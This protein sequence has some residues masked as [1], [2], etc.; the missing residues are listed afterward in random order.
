MIGDESLQGALRILTCI[1]LYKNAKHY[2]YHPRLAEAW[3]EPDH[4]DFE[5]VKSMFSVTLSDETIVSTYNR[6]EDNREESIK[7]EAK[8]MLETGEDASFVCMCA[9]ASVIGA[10]IYSHYPSCGARGVKK[11]MKCIVMPREEVTESTVVHILWSRDSDFDNRPKVKYH[12]NHFVPLFLLSNETSANS[13][14]DTEEPKANIPKL[15]Q[16][17]LQSTFRPKRSITDLP[18]TTS[19]PSTQVTTQSFPILSSSKF[20]MKS[21]SMPLNSTSGSDNKGPAAGK[22]KAAD[23]P[24][25]K[26]QKSLVQRGPVC[27]ISDVN[28]YD[29]GLHH[30]NVVSYTDEQLY[31]LIMNTW[32]PPKDFQFPGSTE[33]GKTRRFSRAWL[34]TYPWLTYSQYYNGCFCLPC[35]LFGRKTGQPDYKLINLYREPF[36][37]WT[38]ASERLKAHHTTSRLHKD[39]VILMELFKKRMQSEIVPIDV[40]AYSVRQERIAKNREKLKSILKTIILCGKQ[41]IPLRGHRDDSKDHESS[42]NPGN[43]QVLLDFRVECGDTVLEEHF[44]TCAKHA[45]YRS[46]TIQ[47]ELID[48]CGDFVKDQI[49][50]EIKDA[51][52]FSILADEVADLTN[53]E[54]MPLVLRF[55]DKE[56]HIREEFLKFVHLA[57]GTSGENMAEAIKT[58]IRSL[59]LDLRNCRGQGYDGAGNMSGKYIGAAVRIQNDFPDAIYVHCASHRLNL[60][61]TNACSV[62][63]IRNTFGTMKAVYDFFN[64]PKRL[65]LLQEKILQVCPE[66]NRRKLIDI[67]KTRWIARIDA[68]EVFETIFQAIVLALE[69][70][71]N[72]TNGTWNS[73][74]CTDANGLFSQCISFEFIV[75][76]IVARNGLSYVAPATAKL[77]RKQM[78]IVKAYSEIGILTK[79]VKEKREK[80]SETH[81]DWYQKSVS[82]AQRVGTTPSTPRTCSKQILR[83]NPPFTSVE[84][85]YRISIS[86]P[87][88]DH[89]SSQLDLRFT[90]EK[91]KV[92]KKG[93]LLI[94][95]HMFEAL[96]KC[97]GAQSWKNDLSDF[98]DRYKS[99]LPLFRNTDTEL[100]IWLHFW[101]SKRS[102]ILP[103]KL[104]ETLETA[105]SMKTTFPSIF[106]LLQI[107]ATIPITT[108]QCERCISRLRL[109]KTYLRSTM[110]QERLNGLAML[111]IHRDKDFDLDDIVNRFALKNER[112]MTLMNILETDDASNS[113]DLP[114]DEDDCLDL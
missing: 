18:T 94:P 48:C 41:N 10:K 76:L 98:I 34:E 49:I 107:L 112:R 28:K 57:N 79:L 37:A 44:Q 101:S 70:V 109:L 102:E 13:I 90:P 6:K 68:L 17:K 84:E 47:N 83:A 61:V 45:T 3:Q 63:S 104:S 92:L 64:W 25:T 38:H 33:F 54:Q 40:L 113:K 43:F 99:D 86:V 24:S 42:G 36:T 96:Q 97:N 105:A 50:K 46:K 88:L 8:L 59:G 82:L 27:S 30:N 111:S 60:C 114:M 19:A 93:F 23:V 69:E 100:D 31:D 20:P 21:G 1:E 15:I 5:S 53:K 95:S 71:K 26:K 32:V 55:V 58:E 85:Y 39:A 52:F 89:L 16:Q 14:S 12:P 106:V 78:E 65:S 110:T 67:C 66:V 35:V 2:A 108:C 56:G 73:D 74:S 62:P 29:I 11:L 91:I 87:F 80:I 9:L 72:N 7:E 4:S 81:N 77:Q 51:K 103:K 75:S 22:R